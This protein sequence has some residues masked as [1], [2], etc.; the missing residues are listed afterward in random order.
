MFVKY[1]PSNREKRLVSEAEAQQIEL[2]WRE[3]GKQR[4]DLAFQRRFDIGAAEH[5]SL[6]RQMI[7]DF[8]EANADWNVEYVL[9]RNSFAQA[10]TH[11]ERGFI[12]F[13]LAIHFNKRGLDFKP[14]LAIHQHEKL[15]S[16]QR[17]SGTVVGVEIRQTDLL[18]VCLACQSAHGQ[19]LLLSDAL[20]KSIL[21]H[22]NCSC[23]R[24]DGREGYCGCEYRPL[25]KG[26]I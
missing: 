7:I 12:A 25:F 20:K 22:R 21:P 13:Q 2:E 6:R 5:D 9:L 3:H 8:G 17:N 19:K 4:A 24:G 26:E 15:L 1:S 14:Y 18:Y 23:I 16:F 11:G 10:Q